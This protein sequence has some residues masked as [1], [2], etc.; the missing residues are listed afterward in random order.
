MGFKHRKITPLWPRTNAESERFRKTIGKAI[1]AA[2]TEHRTWMEEI[3]TFLRNITVQLLICHQPT[4]CLEG[5]LIQNS[6]T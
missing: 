2:H 6:R 1:R 4:F 3:H 5:K